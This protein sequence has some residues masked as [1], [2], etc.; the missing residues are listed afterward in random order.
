MQQQ[1]TTVSSVSNKTPPSIALPPQG[2]GDITEEGVERLSMEEHGETLSS[3]HDVAEALMSSQEL[4]SP[5]WDLPTIKPARP[6]SSLACSTNW[7][8]RG[9]KW[10][11][12]KVGGEDIFETQ[13]LYGPKLIDCARVDK[14]WVLGICL[15]CPPPRPGHCDYKHLLEHRMWRIWWPHHNFY[16][17]WGWNS[18]RSPWTASALLMESSPVLQIPSCLNT[19]KA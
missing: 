16:T 18:H 12:M 3:G 19:Q 7:A 14:Q 15:L 17:S 5:A 13:F 2:S 9:T 1:E 10:R 4:W 6:V 11:G 8:R